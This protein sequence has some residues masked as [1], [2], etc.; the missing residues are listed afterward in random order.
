MWYG[1]GF[2]LPIT[3]V[4]KVHEASPYPI[5]AGNCEFAIDPVTG[6]PIMPASALT[7]A[8]VPV[9]ADVTPVVPATSPNNESAVK[10]V[11]PSPNG[12]RD[13]GSN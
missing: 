10:E 8:T 4:R 13:T 5:M 11:F 3:L 9:A 7:P 1:H 6:V 12:Q 2:F